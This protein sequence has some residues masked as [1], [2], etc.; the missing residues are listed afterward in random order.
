M[1]TARG[2]R[3]YQRHETKALLRAH[4]SAAARLGQHS[5]LHCAVCHRLRR[6]VAEFPPEPFVPPES[7]PTTVP[8][9][10]VAPL[11]ATQRPIETVTLTEEATADLVRSPAPDLPTPRGADDIDAAESA[12]AGVRAAQE[13]HRTPSA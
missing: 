13:P 2:P 6:L 1:A 7:E 8:R 5:T 9:Q 3:Q 11:G 12:A 10:E 4:L